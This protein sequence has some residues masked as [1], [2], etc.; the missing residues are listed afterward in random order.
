[1]ESEFF[2]L[3]LATYE[4]QYANTIEAR[5]QSYFKLFLNSICTS[6]LHANTQLK[7]EKNIFRIF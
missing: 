4:K 3:I 2:Y 5:K 1:M 6:S 7:L